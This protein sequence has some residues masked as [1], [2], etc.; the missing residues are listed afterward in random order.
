MND[1]KQHKLRQKEKGKWK[2][3]AFTFDFF[4]LTIALD[5]RTF[6]KSIWRFSR[7]KNAIC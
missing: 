4:L 2:K 3:I 6:R 1:E 5:S 7:A